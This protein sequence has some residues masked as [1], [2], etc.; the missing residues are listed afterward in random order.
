MSLSISK[1]YIREHIEIMSSV[2]VTL[3]QCLIIMVYLILSAT[4]SPHD[5]A[6]LHKALI[7]WTTFHSRILSKPMT[8][9]R[10]KKNGHKKRELFF[11]TTVVCFENICEQ[12]IRI[13]RNHVHSPPYSSDGSPPPKKIYFFC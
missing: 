3:F 1:K 4:L 11:P 7:N 5:L 10:T 12:G 8:L 9:H 13:I 6:W 2:V